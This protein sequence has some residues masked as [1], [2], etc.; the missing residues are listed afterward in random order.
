MIYTVISNLT[1]KD[2]RTS[3]QPSIYIPSEV[4]NYIL[5]TKNEKTRAERRIAYTVLSLSLEKFFGISS[6]NIQ[7]NAYG[8][9]FLITNGENTDIFI[10]LSH[11]D[12]V[13]AVA[14]S[15]EGEIGVD[16][17]CEISPE[18]KERMS[19]RFLT[20]T[21]IKETDLNVKYFLIDPSLEFTEIFLGEI[22]EKD[23]FLHKWSASEAIMKCHGS[24]FE[25]L[26]KLEEIK[27]NIDLKTKSISDSGRNF[28]LS[29]AIKRAIM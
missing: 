2:C 19:A 20:E 15:D 16:L 12:G 26:P 22:E 24:G 9:P 5:E 3:R 8:K 17:Q 23:D 11:S 4:E 25:A 27:K 29:I 7:K 6:W 14:L 10:S 13:A 28:S 21:E 1:E 18:R